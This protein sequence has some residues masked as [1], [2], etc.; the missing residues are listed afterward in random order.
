MDFTEMAA[1]SVASAMILVLTD[2][3]ISSELAERVKSGM[4]AVDFIRP[5]SLKWYYFFSQ[6]GGNLVRFV[7]EG[8]VLLPFAGLMWHVRLPSW[9]YVLLGTVSLAL[10]ILLL[11]LLQYTAGLLVFWMRDGT[12]TRMA[13]NGLFTLFSGMSVPL[14]FYPDWM[15]DICMALPFRLAVFEPVS[16]WMGRY[17]LGQC[18][19]ILALQGI[20]I[21]A[22]LT[23]EHLLWG[24]IRGIVEIQGG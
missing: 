14:W 2:T 24:H 7:V 17:G 18:A 21:G 4:I 12:Y 8:A 19:E 10:A 6:A 3:R 13:M 22:A 23:A 11:Y 20:W 15:R 5:V 1:Y 16:V 9:E